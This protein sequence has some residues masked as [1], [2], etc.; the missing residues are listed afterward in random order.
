MKETGRSDNALIAVYIFYNAVYATLA[1]PIGVLADKT[2][3]KKI[4]ITGLLFFALV[5]AGMC[6]KGSTYW[7]LFLFFLY[8]IYAAA[9]EGISKAWITKLVTKEKVATAIGTYTGFQS[10]AALLAS[11]I[12]GILWLYFGAVAAF[13]SSAIVTLL[14]LIYIYFKTE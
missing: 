12:A 10:I 9:T 3:L 2:G 8:G 14:V 4:F 1:Y 11:S 5:Y 7:Y 6:V 13:M